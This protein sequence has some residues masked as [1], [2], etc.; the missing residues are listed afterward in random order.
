MLFLVAISDGLDGYLARRYGWQTPLG[1]KLDPI[2]DK[3]LAAT[4]YVCFVWQ[5]LLPLWVSALVLAAML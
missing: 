5:G 1:E 4:L 2:A 3:V